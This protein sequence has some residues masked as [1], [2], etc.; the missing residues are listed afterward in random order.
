MQHDYQLEAF[1]SDSRAPL[2]DLGNFL[3]VTNFIPQNLVGNRFGQVR[4]HANESF[5]DESLVDDR[6]FVSYDP[7]FLVGVCTE[8]FVTVGANLFFQWI[9]LPGPAVALQ[10][11]VSERLS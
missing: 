10:V 11:I 9:K 7:C 8:Q 6:V 5:N 1:N 4:C 2:F 3:Q